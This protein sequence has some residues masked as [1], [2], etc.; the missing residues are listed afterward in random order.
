[1]TTKI[2]VAM[3]AVGV[4]AGCSSTA[5]QDDYGSSVESLIKAQTANPATLTSP[6][7][8]P[9]TGVDPDYAR[10]A[11]EEMRKSVGKPSEVKQP[12]EMLLMGA[13]GGG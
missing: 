6:S 2:I 5:L 9:V 7:D 1:M 8:A 3:A 12:I 13:Q 10:K 11:V 4:L